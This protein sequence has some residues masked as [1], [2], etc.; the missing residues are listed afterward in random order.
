MT[1]EALCEVFSVSFPVFYE[2]FLVMYFSSV[3]SSF[4]IVLCTPF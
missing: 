3:I 2:L 1:N 4:V